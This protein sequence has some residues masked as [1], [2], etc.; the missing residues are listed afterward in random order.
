MWPS[1][2]NSSNIRILVIDD[3]SAIRSS[4]AAFLEDSGYECWTCSNSA[5]ANNLMQQTNFDVCI[6]DLRLPDM[7]G[8]DLI[9]RANEHHPKQRY[10]IYTASG[11]YN[12]SEDLVDIGIRPEHVF[13][14]PVQNMTQL[15]KCIEK[16]VPK[17]LCAGDGKLKKHWTWVR[18]ALACRITLQ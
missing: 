17:P 7:N 13:H 5:E 18:E 4:L 12:L 8:E 1:M 10:I 14:K 15:T 3:D 16:L 11:P 6:I 9:L 2:N